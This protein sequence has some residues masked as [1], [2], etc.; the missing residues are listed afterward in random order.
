[1]GYLGT[2]QK[3][4]LIHWKGIGK[5]LTVLSQGSPFTLLGRVEGGQGFTFHSAVDVP[6][7]KISHHS[8]TFFLAERWQEQEFICH[9][10]VDPEG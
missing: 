8:V 10:T 7:R 6:G 2:S 5:G 3:R 4:L 9:V 1:M